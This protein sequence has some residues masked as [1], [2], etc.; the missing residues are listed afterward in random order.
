MFFN[1]FENLFKEYKFGGWWNWNPNKLKYITS[2]GSDNID[3]FLY[4]S[5]IFHSDK[6]DYMIKP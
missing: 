5:E 1:I 3:Y 2:S 6:G 4:L